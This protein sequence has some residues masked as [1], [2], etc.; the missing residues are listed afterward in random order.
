MNNDIFTTLS[1]FGEFVG[2]A[3]HDTEKS[4]FIPGPDDQFAMI[5]TDNRGVLT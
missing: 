3:H 5:G 2:S 4:R 1:I